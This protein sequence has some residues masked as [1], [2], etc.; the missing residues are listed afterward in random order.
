MSLVVADDP[1]RQR[2]IRAAGRMFR[3]DVA[4]HLE[5]LARLSPDRYHEPRHALAERM[6]PAEGKS[7]G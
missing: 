3:S 7:A 4:A 1:Y 6:L 5:E 2:L